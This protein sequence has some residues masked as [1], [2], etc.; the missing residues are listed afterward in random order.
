MYYFTADHILILVYI[1]ESWFMYKTVC[2]N[3][4]I[5]EYLAYLH[6]YS[7][8]YSLDFFH[9]CN[10]IARNGFVICHYYF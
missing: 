4:Y 9:P 10:P 1:K 3:N 2:S 7:I 6:K 8:M 5:H